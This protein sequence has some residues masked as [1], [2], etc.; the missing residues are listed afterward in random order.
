MKIGIDIQEVR[1]F[2]NMERIFSN[3]EL[4]YINSKGIHARQTATGLYCAKEAFFKALG[5][6]IQL[7]KLPL[8]EILHAKQGAPY[9][10]IKD[11]TLMSDGLHTS[12][13]ISHTKTTAVAMCI[14]SI[15]T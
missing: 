13:S 4:E 15:I 5:T 8:V 11:K 9:Y 1:E 14:I 2:Q 12:L 3:A 6:G 7:S 10:N